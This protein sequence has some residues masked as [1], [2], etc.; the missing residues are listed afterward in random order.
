MT[1]LYPIRFNPIIK[2]RVWGG[3]RLVQEFGKQYTG[4]SPVGES[5]EI[6]G[7]EGDTTVISN[8]FLKK[9]DINEIVETYLGE[10]VGD[11]IYETFGNEFPVLIKLLDIEKELSVQVHPDD[12][13][14]R[15]RHDSYGKTEFWYILE[16]GPDA[17]IYM[18]FNRET[19]PRELYEKCMNDTAPELLNVIHP[20]KGD[21]FLIE[22]GT[23]HAA[24]GGITIAEIQ[25]VSD[26]TYRIYDW[27][28]EHDPATAREMHLDLAIDCI[29]YGKYSGVVKNALSGEQKNGGVLTD[30]DYFKVSALNLEKEIW[31]VSQ[32][33]NSFIIY[34]CEN[35]PITF[36]SK[37]G[38]EKINRGET[39]LIPAHLGEYSVIPEGAGCRMLEITGK[40]QISSEE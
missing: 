9:N 23:V 19:T 3:T 30:C 2:E 10:V 21:C 40:Y 37:N 8:G 28:R 39:I 4:D 12:E 18:G 38:S 17:K 26:V 32:D 25:Q 29:D 22:P 13:T 27:G 31:L 1:L 24:T 7:I 14:A 36:T 11:G 35:G 15:E 34:I 33:F 5:W 20:K 6:S 16:A